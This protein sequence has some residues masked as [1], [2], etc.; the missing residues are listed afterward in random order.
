MPR[1]R[2]KAS[3]GRFLNA[4]QPQ[5]SSSPIADAEKM[6]KDGVHEVENEADEVIASRVEAEELEVRVWSN[7]PSGL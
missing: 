3:P 7:Q 5:A 2:R 4:S 1:E 6:Q